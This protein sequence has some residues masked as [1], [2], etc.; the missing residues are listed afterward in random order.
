MKRIY[1][2]GVKYQKNGKIFAANELQ[3]LLRP[4][5]H[6]KSENVIPSDSEESSCGCFTALALRSA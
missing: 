6:D 2:Y 4:V 3:Y 1:G 5:Q